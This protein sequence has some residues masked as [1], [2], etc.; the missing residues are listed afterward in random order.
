M[1][2]IF[3]RLIWLAIGRR[4][5]T[6]QAAVAGELVQVILNLSLLLLALT[7]AQGRAI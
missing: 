1:F 3:V 7:V 4:I 2:G 6:S 5:G